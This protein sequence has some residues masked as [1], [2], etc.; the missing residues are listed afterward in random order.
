MK[1]SVKII[2]VVLLVFILAA[3]FLIYKNRNTLGAIWDSVKL[4]QSDVEDKL[5]KDKESLQTFIDET[6]GVTV[7]ELTEEESKALESGELSEE[8][9]IGIITA[10]NKAPSKDSPPANQKTEEDSA[11]SQA[12]AKLYIQ[13][14]KYLGN[15]DSIEAQVRQE[16]SNMSAEEKKTGKTTLLAKHLPTVMAWEKECDS[17]VYG[18]ID[19]IKAELE[20]SGGDLSV[21]EKLKET[22]L[23][24]KRAKK[25]Y[26]INKYM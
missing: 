21:I 2:L 3:G 6:D 19:E 12:I 9:V 14:S 8:E 10:P 22:Y 25:S 26:F 13:K 1:K 20:K 18:I 23:S 24:E 17:V 16:Y 5:Q 4:E 11:V 7:R 15:L